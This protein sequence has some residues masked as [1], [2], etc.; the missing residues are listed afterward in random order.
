MNDSVAIFDI[1]SNAVR[2]VIYGGPA[3]APMKIHN[4]RNLCGL[5]AGVAANGRLD[6]AARD[7]AEA[8]LRRF[9]GLVAALKI[10]TVRAVA[11]AAL[12]DAADGAEFIGKLGRELGLD[13]RIVDGKE[14]A[15]L[16]AAG[17]MMNGLGAN[18]VIGDFGGGSLELIATEN[19]AVKKT[20]SLP[21]GSHRLHALSTRHQKI[22]V[23]D[24]ALDTVDF[25]GIGGGFM[26]PDMATDL[27]GTGGDF[28]ALG[29]A[30]RS[31]GRAHMHYARYPLRVLDHYGITGKRAVDFA[32]LLSH[33]SPAALEKTVG[34][35]RKRA[36]DVGIAALVMERLFERLRPARL[37]FSGT[38]LR[39][40]LLFDT[41]P[42]EVRTQDALIAGCE[43]FAART[44]RM[45]D[46]DAFRALTAWMAPLS[47]GGIARLVEATCLLS[48]IAGFE[49]ED[50][51]AV[52]AFHRAFAFPF[53]AAS[54]TTR[55]FVALALCVRY[56]GYLRR[57]PRDGT[58]E[59]PTRPAQR[60]LGEKMT[61]L[62]VQTGLAVRA[63]YL[64]TGGALHLLKQTKLDVTEA[65][66]TLSLPGAAAP[67]NAESVQRAMENLGREMGRAAKIRL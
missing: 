27:P 45:G 40:G 56:R 29:G 16:S 13:I 11:T 9:A 44:S 26:A 46:L 7:K 14:E 58:E 65:A 54:H 51:Q 35:A 64:L 6:P 3:R 63:A 60:I 53:Y 67:L 41:L 30:W 43:D 24:A 39:E 21:I 48:D 17:V 38:G 18:G 42:A 5:G 20:A 25:I 62:A 22:K 37:I 52:Q 28:I 49:H 33:Q 2:L 19:G 59:D 1:G 36:P 66:V 4:E 23:I 15:H 50:S 55:A 31:M 61:S 57:T 12:R 10:G 47:E 32:T 8:S 34:L